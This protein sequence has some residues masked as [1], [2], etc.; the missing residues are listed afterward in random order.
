MSVKQH[1]IEFR[2]ALSKG[3]SAKAEEEFE[4]A[5]NEAFLY[6]QQKLANNEKFDISNED[7]LFALVTLFDNIIGYYKEGMYEEGISYCEN[8]IELV[9]SPKLKE[10]F[11]G[12]SLGMQKGVDIDTFFREY[13]DLSKVD[14]EFPM[15][16]CNFKEKIKELIE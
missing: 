6:Y 8:L 14:A 7:E 16:L 3:D 11:K 5:F 15:F 1:Y 2:N 10:M 4:K 12:F 13:V 9:D